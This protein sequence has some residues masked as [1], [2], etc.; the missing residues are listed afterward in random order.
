MQGWGSG[1][2]S[3]QLD[4]GALSSP[5]PLPWSPTLWMHCLTGQCILVAS[6]SFLHTVAFASTRAKLQLTCCLF[7]L[8]LDSMLGWQSVSRQAQGQEMPYEMHESLNKQVTVRIAK[9]IACVLVFALNGKPYTVFVCMLFW[10]LSSIF[11][12]G[13]HICK[14]LLHCWLTVSCTCQKARRGVH[15]IKAASLCNHVPHSAGI[16]HIHQRR[17]SEGLPT[18]LL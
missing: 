1:G 17:C 11:A 14:R 7:P 8:V 10:A 18:N 2:G 9:R 4:S 13:D 3:L 15:G 12:W 16:T 6:T 5:S